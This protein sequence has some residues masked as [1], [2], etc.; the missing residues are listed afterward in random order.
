MPKTEEQQKTERREARREALRAE[1]R[2]EYK[3]ELDAQAALDKKAADAPVVDSK[4]KPDPEPDAAAIAAAA[5]KA[6]RL[7]PHREALTR[8][9]QSKRITP[10]D[11]TAIETD[12]QA[13]ENPAMVA[14][15]LSALGR[16]PE[17]GGAMSGAQ[18]PARSGIM[19][20]ID[21]LIGNT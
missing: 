14:R 4:T 10:A 6:T 18:V 13:G 21:N 17:G 16:L 15:H 5:A 9:V 11:R 12:I 19:T 1:G 7:D 8:L 3:A 20:A 2:A